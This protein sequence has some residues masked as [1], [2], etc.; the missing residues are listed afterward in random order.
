MSFT[1]ITISPLSISPPFLAVATA[2][3]G[4]VGIL[5]HEFCSENSFKD[6]VD[7]IQLLVKTTKLCQR[8]G[9]RLN[10]DDY[11]YNKFQMLLNPL[12][13][14]D[15]WVIL[16][17]WDS[18]SL[19]EQIS[20][21][22][23]SLSRYILLEITDLSDLNYLIDLEGLFNGFLAKGNECGGFVGQDSVFILIQRLLHKYHL[24]LYIQGSIGIYTAAACRSVGAAGVVLDDC[25]L[26]MP[27]SPLPNL[28]KSILSKSVSTDTVLIGN[29]RGIRVFNYPG[30]YRIKSFGQKDSYL[31]KDLNLAF[32]KK[33]EQAIGWGDPSIMAWPVGQGIGL[34]AKFSQRYRTSGRFIRALLG[35][36]KATVHLGH[37]LHVLRTHGPIAN[38]HGTKYPIVQG[39]MTRVSDT[40]LFAEA[41][42]NAGALP[43]L[44]LGVMNSTDVE[45]LLAA[46]QARLADKPWGVGLLGFIPKE[47]LSAQMALIRS[48]KP[49]FALLA[50]GHADQ[51]AWLEQAGISTYLHAPTPLL[52]K[53]FYT[54]GVRRFIFEGREC[55]GHIGPL[56]SFALWEACVHTLLELVPESA[57]SELHLLFAGGIH[58]GLSAGIIEVITAPLAK[59]GMKVGVLVGTA[60]LLTRE[61]V[62]TGAILS[63]YQDHVIACRRT[64]I[65]STGSGHASRCAVTP[66]V[67]FYEQTASRL[68]SEGRK[69][70]DISVALNSLCLGRLRLATKGLIRRGPE[71]VEVDFESQCHEGM[72]MI[73]QVATLRSEVIGIESLHQSICEPNQDGMEAY[74]PENSPLETDLDKNSVMSS[75]IAIIGIGV[76]LPRAN[77][78][79]EFWENILNKV[80][81]ITEIPA[82]RWDWR[83]YYDPDPKKRDKVYSKWGCFI[84]EV[85][86]DPARFGIPPKSLP[87]IDP[88]QLLSL[89]AV[90]RALE[91]A[92]YGNGDFDRENTSVI[93][94]SIA[95]GELAEH[96]ITRSEL[97]Q[98][99]QSPPDVLLEGLPEWAPDSFPGTLPNVAAGRVANRFDLGGANFNVD[100]ACAS[101]LTAIDLAVI[102]LETG[103]SNLVIAGGIETKLSPYAYLC[104]SNTLALTPRDHSHPFDT[105]ADGLILGEGF[106]VVILK[107]LVDAEADGD[108]IY[109]VVKGAGS[110]SD[111][112]A[113]GLTAPRSSGQLKAFER[114]YHKAGV[115]PRTIGLYEAHGTGTRLGDKTEVRSIR[116]F[117]IANG[118]APKSCAVGSI[119]ALIGH[120]KSTAGVASLI[121]ASLALYYRTIPPQPMDGMPIAPLRDLKSPVYLPEDP[122]P[123][124]VSSKEPRRAGVSAFGF[125]GTNC[126]CVLEEY[127]GSLNPRT[128][129]RDLWPYE[130]VLITG[131]DK[132]A[133][134]KKIIELLSIIE[135]ANKN[136]RLRDIA[137]QCASQLSNNGAS[138]NSRLAIVAADISSLCDS[139][140]QTRAYLV[141]S[142]LRLLSPF[143]Q[144]TVDEGSLS[145]DGE[146]IAFLFP[147]QGAQYLGMA[148][149]VALLFD[150]MR[151]AL[152]TANQVLSQELMQPLSQIIFGVGHHGE[153]ERGNSSACLTR[154]E[155]AQPAI[156]AVELGYLDILYSL[157]IQPDMVGGHSFGE[158]C[159]LYAG[160]LLSSQDFL[161]LSHIRG[162]AMAAASDDGGMAAVNAVREEV[163]KF[164][165]GTEVILANHNAPLQS[166]I[167]GNREALA[168]V[169]EQLSKAG[170]HSQ[171]LPVSGAFHSPLIRAS[172][173]PLR[174]AI[175]K[176]AFSSQKIPI[177]SNIDGHP[178][179]Q[180]S[181]AIRDRISKHL[182]SPVEFVTQI[183]AMHAAGARYFVEVGPKSI[184]TGLITQ[185]LND[186]PHMAISVDGF[187]GGLKGLLI[188]LGA[189]FVHGLTLKASVL[190]TGRDC[191]PLKAMESA[192]DDQAPDQPM[193]WFVSGGGVRHHDQP[194]NA[195]SPIKIYPCQPCPAPDVP[196]RIDMSS[197][198]NQKEVAK[199]VA[200]GVHDKGLEERM[201]TLTSHSSV[202]AA[203]AAYQMYQQT[204]QQFLLLQEQVM[205][206]FLRGDRE[207]TQ[208]EFDEEPIS[209][210]SPSG[211]QNESLLSSGIE[212]VPTTSP[213]PGMTVGSG[214]SSANE[215]EIGKETLVQR[216]LGVVSE[217][218]GYPTEMLGLDLSLESELGIDS[219]KR[220]E[221]LAG[222][223]RVLP[224]S[225]A[226]AIA[227]NIEAVRQASTINSL[228][229]LLLGISQAKNIDKFLAHLTVSDT[230]V[231]GAI[232]T[233]PLA[234]DQLLE[235]LIRVVSESTGYPPEMLGCDLALEAEL[236]I[237][238]IKRVEILAGIQRVLPP[239][240]A[241]TLGTHIEQIRQ[242]S[243]LNSLANTLL[244]LS[245]EGRQPN[246]ESAYEEPVKPV[247]VLPEKELF[248]AAPAR[249]VRYLM[250]AR[251]VPLPSRTME[252]VPDELVLVTDDEQGVGEA[253]VERLRRAGARAVLLR[254]ADSR[255]PEEITDLVSG[256]RVKYGPVTRVVHLTGLVSKHLPDDFTQWR[257]ATWGQVKVLFHL[258]KACSSD[259]RDR[260][261]RVLSASMLGGAFGRNGVCGPALPVSGGNSG[262]LNTLRL[263][264]PEVSVRMLDFEPASVETLVVALE[265]EIFA[266]D[267][268]SEIG[269]RDGMRFVYTPTQVNLMPTG[270]SQIS[271]T[272]DWVVLAL[273]GAR[274]ITAEVLH[275][276]LVPGMTLV[277]IGLSPEPGTESVSTQGVNDVDAL[278]RLFIAEARQAK[279]QP[280]PIE[281][282]RRIRQVQRNRQIRANVD[283]LKA[284]G[285]QVE[286]HSVDATNPD[287]LVAVIKDLY[288][289]FGRIDA[290]IQGVGI[291]EDKLILD[292]SPS[293]FDRV[294][295]TKVDSTYLLTR[296]LN[297]NSLKLALLFASVAGRTGNRGQ[298]DYA[299]ANEVINR[300]AWWMHQHW[301]NTRVLS[302]NWGPWE[303]TGMASEAVNRQF[304]AR[305]VVPISPEAGCRFL[306]EELEFGD[307][308]QVEIIAGIFH[309]D[310]EDAD[311]PHHTPSVTGA[312]PL[313][314]ALTLEHPDGVMELPYR[315]SLSQSPYLDD[316][317]L[318][319]VP[320][321]PAAVALELLAEFVQA[322][323]PELTL[324]EVQ[325]LRVLNGL[326]MPGDRDREVI[327]RARL[328]GVTLMNG[329]EVEADIVE[330]GSR[331]PF[332]RARLVLTYQFPVGTPGDSSSQEIPGH[333]VP[334]EEIYLEHCFQGPRLQL[335]GG[336]E[337]L[338]EFGLDG[339]VIPSKPCDW[340]TECPVGGRWLFDPGL[341]DALLQSAVVWIHK[342]LG[343]YA[344]PTHF[345]RVVRYGFVISGQS[346]TFTSR[347]LDTSPTQVE[348]EFKVWDAAGQLLLTLDGMVA[349]LSQGLNRLAPVMKS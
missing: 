207:K 256:V 302:I 7:N 310:M 281:I 151:D 120:T 126:H 276:L 305:G 244:A 27:E 211:G 107:R 153:E 191:Q 13:D 149:E 208:K 314:N 11:D 127:R 68:Y 123:W 194:P 217:C 269:F 59:R 326:T 67:K 223:E 280:K 130:L 237:D 283:A 200:P 203:V 101:S 210:E 196:P 180:D 141:G 329:L 22:P 348:M 167:S 41:V 347:I 242:A 159:A 80:D 282:D 294:F 6:L 2:R 71:L 239:S 122:L 173:M 54:Q 258:L 87:Y 327:L 99:I 74:Q 157:G 73:G 10:F 110:S 109:A 119:K 8:I 58:D 82:S 148:R 318:D 233:P 125:G 131:A 26:L 33:Y 91:D 216:I 75:D 90:R 86:F 116:D 189:L 146:L 115:G 169:L 188:A 77:T 234:R 312:F 55:G 97:P 1:V 267:D 272:S 235:R 288:R 303:V 289:R 124:L 263:E 98:R 31:G 177:F 69:P 111:G 138:H 333:G 300:M 23:K 137:Y 311:S 304:R 117:L 273:G 70:N 324:S 306:K 331:R 268:A 154:T 222:I 197:Q 16:S 179:P 60:Y 145:G 344:L 39:P 121:K 247:Q 108:R 338:T 134:L 246:Q 81:A 178:Y 45:R 42:A 328:I 184:L 226:N 5:D 346:L 102:Q 174:E 14:R 241:E 128:T 255:T 296:H 240:M 53:L 262:L 32:I 104:F 213:L 253:L 293:S 61:A 63:A 49:K 205:A 182:L 313:L 337:R 254:I 279:Q 349:S 287:S 28:W 158:Y 243:T 62:E 40:E 250:Q 320:V 215:S 232:E 317:R 118:A 340:I 165:N 260:A 231:P 259:L 166:V 336:I 284:A 79:N 85:P 78:S 221:I 160:G 164:L 219:I 315:L 65:L 30:N 298:C 83:L 76:I 192:D 20:T 325:D 214:Q 113:L 36:S 218:T 64:S 308:N 50:G 198:T 193:Q 199:Q 335:L 12:I 206:R 176:V 301:P 15:H 47:L 57:S 24:P 170:I 285:A 195:P 187:G 252:L 94:G 183:E 147:G 161:R 103:R 265:A 345:R 162:R 319:G 112:K 307:P 21:F 299:S 261:G 140:N 152:E 225:L 105:D 95:L 321:V 230:G 286:Y 46:T 202:E 171:P 106:A 139:L 89:E 278:R 229:E 143:I 316:H 38:S 228:V 186:R 209:T 34:A 100:S 25:L 204:M 175:D 334:R 251:Q 266:L 249:C 129:G 342:R 332:Y 142:H 3:V 220:V 96:Y 257:Q 275:S 48:F 339:M 277:L 271:P 291:I 274:G 227:A 212:S 309:L 51:V 19:V 185:I 245:T 295:D 163:E 238:S 37:D 35:T 56:G 84:D 18:R 4:G 290:L 88:L 114:A 322:G 132:D 341:I 156:G 93:F 248:P 17:H 9:L 224:A 236:G 92:G 264:W 292:K 270:A 52:L 172:Q 29:N 190:F 323:W 155:V 144:L 44:A 136:L 72:Y 135:G 330:R 297:Q 66:F 343:T 168:Q 201:K 150:P 43:M 181:D 133:L